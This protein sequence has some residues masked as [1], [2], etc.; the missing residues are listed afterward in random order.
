MLATSKST[1]LEVFKRGCIAAV[2]A[3]L[4]DSGKP[5]S[6]RFSADDL[7]ATAADTLESDCERF[8]SDYQHHLEHTDD[9]GRAGA[10]FWRVRNGLGGFSS[11]SGWPKLQ[12]LRLIEASESYGALVVYAEYG[13]LHV[14]EG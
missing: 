9:W 12:G 4:D 14:T 11:N 3:E 5:Y 2:L 6:K 8:F 7:S 1:E 10:D 13:R